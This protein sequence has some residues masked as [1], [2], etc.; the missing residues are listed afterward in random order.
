MALRRIWLER[1]RHRALGQMAARP[2]RGI[3]RRDRPILRNCI[4]Q[5]HRGYDS[6]AAVS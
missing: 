6:A 5:R 3:H 2:N 4:R 1:P